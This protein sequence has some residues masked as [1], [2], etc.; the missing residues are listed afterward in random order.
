MEERI[1]ED[2]RLGR[3]PKILQKEIDP[4]THPQTQ[5]LLWGVVGKGQGLWTLPV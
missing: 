1:Q 4:S 2:A 3:A 5:W